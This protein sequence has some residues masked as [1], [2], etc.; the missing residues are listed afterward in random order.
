[1][2]LLSKEE[3]E[4]LYVLDLSNTFNSKDSLGIK[5]PRGLYKL[6]V[7]P[8]RTYRTLNLAVNVYYKT[9]LASGYDLS[10]IGKGLRYNEKK[11][12]ILKRIGYTQRGK[13]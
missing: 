2:L 1:L 8:F 3:L 9:V 10:F 6:K 12:I 7:L 5:V 11:E 13:T 4:V